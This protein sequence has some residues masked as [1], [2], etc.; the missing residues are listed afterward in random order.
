MEEFSNKSKSNNQTDFTNSIPLTL[1]P[2]TPQNVTLH[3]NMKKPQADIISMPL[4]KTNQVKITNSDSREGQKTYLAQISINRATLHI[5]DSENVSVK[6]GFDTMIFNYTVQSKDN[7]S[8]YAKFDFEVQFGPKKYPEVVKGK[9]FSEIL[10]PNEKR[11]SSFVVHIDKDANQIILNIKDSTTKNT[12]LVIP[13]EIK[14]YKSKCKGCHGN[15]IF[16]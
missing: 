2:V 14:D 7:R 8:F 12:L 4:S 10:H 13:I 6:S 3:N 16:D 11:N 15:L 1:F 9:E 5:K